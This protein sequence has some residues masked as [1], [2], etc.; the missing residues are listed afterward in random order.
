MAPRKRL[1]PCLLPLLALSVFLLPIF[2]MGFPQG[3]DWLF[4]LVRVVEFKSAM[5][6]GQF[7]P[8]WA[9]NLYR[10]YGSP[11]FIFYAPLYL[12]TSSLCSVLAG[13]ISVG[14]ALSLIIFSLAAVFCVKILLD[15]VLNKKS[16]ENDSASRIAVYFFILHPYLI[17]DMYLRNANA[18]FAALCVSPLALCGLLIID[19][20]PRPGGLLLAA[21]LALTITAHNLTALIIF[22]VIIT[23]SLVMYLPKGKISLWVTI[24][25]S[26]VLGLGLSAF[27]WVPSVYYKS[28]VQ[29]E[30]MTSGK[31]D[32]HNQFQP[33]SS[34]FGYD[35]FFS[36]GLL[37]PLVLL[38]A[39]DVIWVAYCRNESSCTK[40]I[41]FALCVSVIFLFLQ[42]RASVF[43]WDMVPYMKLFQFPWRMMG[44][45][46]LATS[47]VAGLSFA[48]ICKGK[49]KCDVFCLEIIFLIFCIMNAMPHLRDVKP[50]PR[51]VAMKL[52]YILSGE[53]INKEGF[54]ATV[55]D[56]YLPRF[57]H[58]DIRD[59]KAT[60][61][62]L[63]ADNIADIDIKV[64]KNSG[65]YISLATNAKDSGKLQM[66]RWYFPGWECTIN[67]ESQSVGTN[68]SGS[69]N[70][71][72]S[73]GFNQITLQL[74]A[75]LLRRACVWIS[76]VSLSIWCGILVLPAIKQ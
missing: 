66:A 70:I 48:Y 20:R 8:Y 16:F 7:P 13:S 10:G 25:E 61:K 60:N 38:F 64:L 18:E 69:I 54:S 40:P 76:L 31:F 12:F 28:L 30:Q 59:R 75:P 53:I 17:C 39:I 27:F 55:L 41:V 19:R 56:E 51:G 35:S 3:H 46:A 33:I 62:V 36:T 68:K 5:F 72:I 9:E 11:I 73:S 67:S 23:A 4:E 52:P 50:L 49:S 45:L 14:S 42:T 34:F 58:A 44:P 24:V 32:F 71:S 1:L 43:I 47:M 6:N 2:A 21:G 63:A 26:V 57:A 37:T 22:A 74:K 29:I 15:A 65:T